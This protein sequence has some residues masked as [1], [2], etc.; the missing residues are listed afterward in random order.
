[1]ISDDSE[2]ITLF[3]EYTLEKIKSKGFYKVLGWGTYNGVE[4]NVEKILKWAQVKTIS[5]KGLC[6]FILD[7]KKLD[8][9]KMICSNRDSR[10]KEFTMVSSVY[11]EKW[12]LTHNI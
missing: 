6:Q 3:M 10:L 11:G 7:P 8:D 12:I 5:T 2:E 4:Q 9:V 1:M